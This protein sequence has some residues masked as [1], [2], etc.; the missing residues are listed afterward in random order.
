M[1][2]GFLACCLQARCT[3]EGSYELLLGNCQRAEDEDRGSNLVRSKVEVLG[4]RAAG[5]R[6]VTGHP[7]Q[8]T[9]DQA[10]ISARHFRPYSGVVSRRHLSTRRQ[11][12]VPQ[13]PSR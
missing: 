6:V 5:L 2:I 3:P 1:K 10:T 7:V 4:C 13:F 8:D 9:V 12:G 11:A